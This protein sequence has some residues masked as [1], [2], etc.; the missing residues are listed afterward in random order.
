ML[1]VDFM[2]IMLYCIVADVLLQE[3]RV[4]FPFTVLFSVVVCLSSVVIFYILFNIALNAGIPALH[5]HTNDIETLGLFRG[6]CQDRC[7]GADLGTSEASFLFFLLLCSFI[8]LCC[9]PYD[10]VLLFV[11]M[12]VRSRDS[13]EVENPGNNLYVTGLSAR[14]T[15]RDLEEHFSSEGTVCLKS[16]FFIIS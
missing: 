12:A 3:T 2:L 14:V 7:Q 4:S 13:I 15:K 8:M 11:K 1:I 10:S 5:L 9:Y 16:L 6:H